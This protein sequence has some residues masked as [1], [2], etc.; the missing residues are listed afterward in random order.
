M[1]KT[2]SVASRYD[3]IDCTRG[4]A[5]LMVVLQHSLE[6]IYPSFKYWS[7]EIFNFGIFGVVLFFLVSG[8]VIP[9]SLERSGLLIFWI[10]RFFRLYPIYWLSIIL[11]IVFMT[12]GVMQSTSKIDLTT[13]VANFSMLQEFIR[14]PHILG[15]YWTLSMEMVFYFL[16]SLIFL[17]PKLWNSNK[18]VYL[19]ILSLLLITI[20]TF[21]LKLNI[22]LGR[23]HVLV[24]AFIGM[25][26]FKL[27]NKGIPNKGFGFVCVL[28]FF[29]LLFTAY[30]RYMYVPLLRTESEP[31][32]TFFCVITS[33]IFSYFFFFCL[34]LLRHLK[35]SKILLSLGSMCYSSYLLHPFVMVLILPQSMSQALK[36]FTIL[37]CTISISWISW[38]YFE[39]YF[40][41]VGRD[42]KNNIR[43]RI[44]T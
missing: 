39:K 15:L 37:G 18:L 11:A 13:V 22:P 33:W 28:L 10:S 14:R 6:S 8:Y 32:F 21:T 35:F 24:A 3:F 41:G 5:A 12:L 19:S 17:I 27:V 42:V 36:L 20:I 1:N 38:N 25:Y 43:G 34:V 7:L 2:N 26:S 29:T 31:S 40:I 30:T 44:V 16:C 9:I 23:V 4:V